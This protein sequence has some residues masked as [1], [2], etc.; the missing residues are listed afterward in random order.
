[1]IQIYNANPRSETPCPNCG[2][3]TTTQFR[4]EPA[5]GDDAF[6]ACEFCIEDVILSQNDGLFGIPEWNED[7]DILDEHE[8]LRVFDTRFIRQGRSIRR[9]STFIRYHEEHYDLADS[10]AGDE[11]T[12][13]TTGTDNGVAYLPSPEQRLRLIKMYDLLTE[14]DLSQQ[15]IQHIKER[16]RNELDNPSFTQ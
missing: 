5:G 1:M 2:T 14:W 8:F 3:V 10:L 9:D 7:K 6:K 11:L 15:R 16:L 13:I 12:E 4:V